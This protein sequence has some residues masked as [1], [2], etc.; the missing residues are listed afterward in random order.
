MTLRD[1]GLYAGSIVA[2]EHP[3]H[4]VL[5]SVAGFSAEDRAD[6]PVVNLSSWIF[7]AFDRM[8]LRAPEFDWAGLARSGRR[9][10]RAARFGPARRPS[11]WISLAEAAPR[12][13]DGVAY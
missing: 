1:V 4:Q 12:P 3:A 6:G 5:P 9:L 2:T 7:P 10:V 11:E 13:A 8:P